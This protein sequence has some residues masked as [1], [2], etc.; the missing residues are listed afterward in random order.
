MTTDIST[1][2][3]VR[4]P[5]HNMDAAM[6]RL[7]A[8]RVIEEAQRCLSIPMGLPY[9]AAWFQAD[10][11]EWLD[12][13]GMS[14]LLEVPPAELAQRIFQFAPDLLRAQRC[15][16]CAHLLHVGGNGR[17][18]CDLGMWEEQDK[19]NVEY[20]VST[21]RHSSTRFPGCHLFEKGEVED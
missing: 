9:L 13:A 12:L 15:I 14:H 21:V 4:V 20:A 18:Q 19:K 6:R 16:Y 10:G 11:R 2:D 7:A 3:A 1:W 17:V 5:S 8:A